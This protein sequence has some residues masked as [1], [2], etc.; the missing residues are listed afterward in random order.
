[1]SSSKNFH[2]TIDPGEKWYLFSHSAL[3]EM[4]E[5]KVKAEL[6]KAAERA[7]TVLVNK[8]MD[9]SVRQSVSDAIC[10]R[11]GNVTNT[12]GSDV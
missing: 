11:V 7:W 9:W 8:G 1:M 10:S 3:N 2:M 6:E 4:I 12:G 5:N